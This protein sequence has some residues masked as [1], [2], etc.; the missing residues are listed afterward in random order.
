MAM[1]DGQ[2]IDENGNTS[3]TMLSEQHAIERLQAQVVELSQLLVRLLTV[4]EQAA[5]LEKVRAQAFEEL[6]LRVKRAAVHAGLRQQ[7]IDALNERISKL[8]KEVRNG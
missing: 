8:E 6:D 3:T 2:S 4:Q 5:E 1:I 7:A